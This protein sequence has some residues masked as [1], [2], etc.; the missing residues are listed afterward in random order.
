VSSIDGQL[1]FAIA[2]KRLIELSY[3]GRLRVAEPHD[4]GVHKG[5]TRLLIYQRRE[6]GATQAK[7]RVGWRLLDVSKIEGCV[8]LDDTFPGSRGGPH[9][10]H[11]VWD[12]VYAR[13]A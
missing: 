11:H 8:V 9:Q 6:S 13:L 12:V 5:T 4:Y 7:G 10:H 1:R 2:N 3:G